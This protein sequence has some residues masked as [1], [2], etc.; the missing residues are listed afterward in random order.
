MLQR[1]EIYAVGIYGNDEEVVFVELI[2]ETSTNICEISKGR[3][4]GYKRHYRI[5]S[6]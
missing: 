3:C 2:L 5:W 6:T 1:S 4:L